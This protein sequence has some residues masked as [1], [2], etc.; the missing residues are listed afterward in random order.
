MNR[1]KK[2]TSVFIVLV[3]AGL[4]TTS[5]ALASQGSLWPSAGGNRQNTR[6]QDSEHTL[7]V[8]NISSLTTKWTFTTGGDVSATPAVDVDTVYFP[9]WAGNLYAVDKLTGVQKWKVS[10]AAA[11]GVPFDKTRATPAV[12]DNLVIVGTQGSIFAPGGGP[13]AKMLAFNKFTG[14]LVWST[15]LD[16]HP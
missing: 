2:L 9:D 7:S 10:I 8:S 1:T 16:N 13:G 3:I 15:Q 4:L 5:L 6:Y 11:S 14:A 12:T